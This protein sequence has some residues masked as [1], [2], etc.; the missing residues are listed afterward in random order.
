MAINGKSRYV[1]FCHI[2]SYLINPDI[3]LN[4]TSGSN[5]RL[6]ER[7]YDD[8]ID[9]TL[10]YNPNAI[11]ELN[12]EPLVRES[13]YFAQPR[14]HKGSWRETIPLKDVLKRKLI[15]PSRSPLLRLQLGKEAQQ[16]G[17]ETDVVFEIDSVATI[18]DLVCHDLGGTVLPFGALKPKVDSGELDAWPISNPALYR[19]LHVAQSPAHPSSK[20][21]TVVGKLVRDVVE[22]F[23]ENNQIGWGL[24]RDVK[25]KETIPSVY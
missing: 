21:F 16:I 17:L 20:A 3:T 19:T 22:K 24:W 4:I 10:T 6:M 11:K 8:R 15:L 25:E 7:V 18:I 13:L 12:C 9:F 14:S 1:T 2:N 5:E 23:A